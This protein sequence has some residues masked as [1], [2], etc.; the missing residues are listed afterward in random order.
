MA[1][2]IVRLKNKKASL[3]LLDFLEKATVSTWGRFLF[4]PSIAQSA[5]NGPAEST[6]RLAAI[7]TMVV[8]IRS[9]RTNAKLIRLRPTRFTPAMLEF[10][11]VLN[12]YHVFFLV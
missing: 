11:A 9:S 3:L 1:V 2:Q 5:L 12:L 8:F 10:P 6:A 7:H 4:R